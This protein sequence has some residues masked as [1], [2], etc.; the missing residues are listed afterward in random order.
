M[1]TT[2]RPWRLEVWDPGKE[3]WEVWSTYVSEENAAERR[4]KLKSKGYD[5][6]V[7]SVGPE[8][9]FCGDTHPAPYDGSCLL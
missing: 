6:Q 2:E 3:K 1:K 5:A 8:C 4:D 7:T 9:D